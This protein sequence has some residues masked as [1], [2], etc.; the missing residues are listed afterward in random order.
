MEDERVV[1][2]LKEIE[3]AL[4]AYGSTEK[5]EAVRIAIKRIESE[6]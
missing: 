6:E 3:C 1:E 5:A 4:T 2:L